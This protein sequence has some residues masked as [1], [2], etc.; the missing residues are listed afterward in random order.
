MLSAGESNWRYYRR[1]CCTSMVYSENRLTRAIH[2]GFE[3]LLALSQMA[4]PVKPSQAETPK[5][6]ANADESNTGV[7]RLARM[8][9][10]RNRLPIARPV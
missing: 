3:T 7:P 1:N 6:G 8:G 4:A 9:Q 10:H 2:S 5:T